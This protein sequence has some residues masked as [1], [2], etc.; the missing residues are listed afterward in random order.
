MPLLSHFMIITFPEFNL[1]FLSFNA[2]LNLY[3]SL[4]QWLHMKINEEQI[5]DERGEP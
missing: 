1:I 3:A 2:A 4:L 5:D